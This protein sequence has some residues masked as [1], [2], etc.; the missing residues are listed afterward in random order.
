MIKKNIFIFYFLF[1]LGSYSINAQDNKIDKIH[2]YKI[3]Y[4]TEQLNLTQSESEKF[5]TLYNNYD[6]EVDD[7]RLKSKFK[8]K[9]QI[10]QAGSINA[11]TESKAKELVLEMQSSNNKIYRITNSFYNEL[12]NIIPYKKIIKLQVAEREFHKKL[13]R[14]YQ[15]KPYKKDND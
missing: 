12:S 10:K 4:L 8:I 14:K 6:K 3:A 11:L 2:A 13:L 5:W 1:V 15:G 7:I 9:N